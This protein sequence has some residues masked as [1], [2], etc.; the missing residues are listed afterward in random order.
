MHAGE[1]EQTPL[2][3]QLEGRLRQLSSGTPDLKYLLEGEATETVPA[4]VSDA[5]L[6]VPESKDLRAE[7]SW[8]AKIGE[9]GGA[10]RGGGGRGG[11]EG[12]GTLI[13]GNRQIEV[14]WVESVEVQVINV[15]APF[16]LLS[17]LKSSLLPKEA[18]HLLPAFRV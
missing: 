8:T 10:K 18:S 12:E 9:V 14:S 6:P 5:Q 3:A 1:A 15:T 13:I 2:D 7:T 4:Q 16:V 17:E 11:G